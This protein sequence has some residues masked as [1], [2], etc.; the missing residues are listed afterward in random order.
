MKNSGTFQIL[1]R[2]EKYKIV[3]I[4]KG[5]E[6]VEFPNDFKYYNEAVSYKK[7]HK[8]ELDEV[9]TNIKEEEKAKILKE[10]EARK[11]KEE[12][13]RA[14]KEEKEK[15]KAERDEKTKAFFGNGW[16]KF[17]S[18]ALIAA[19]LL[20]GG[21]FV[22]KGISSA[23]KN[24]DSKK[25]TTSQTDTTE[26]T[27]SVKDDINNIV[28]YEEIYN[29]DNVEKTVA[30]FAKQYVD[31]KVNITTED[32]LKFV[33]IANIDKLA[34]ENPEFARELFSTQTAEEYLND[35]AKVIGL[36]DMYNSNKWE[37]EKSTKNFIWLSTSIP[38]GDPQKAKMQ[39]L[40]SYVVR[41]ADA[42]IL[43][44]EEEVNKIVGELIESL[45]L[46]D[47]SL[48]AL[49]DGVEFAAQSY[50]S[51][52]NTSIAV[53]YLNKEYRDFFTTRSSAEQNV[54]NI[55]T[56]YNRCITTGKVRTK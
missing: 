56:V 8:S 11:A 15:K 29:T 25:T 50:F 30:E 20:T 38:E 6:L 55:F 36:T 37:E 43:E 31:N 28:T 51:T 19:M 42:A 33:S 52:I 24:R 26:P 21:H 48:N 45:I 23:I 10:E 9:V 53:N 32:L 13:E 14:K 27:I 3:Y 4:E 44:N 7:D 47:G 40:E 1:K 35:A 39:E 22:G 5:I 12:A 49:D 41:I 16:V 46:P 2:G 18:G 54:S 34:E 17:T